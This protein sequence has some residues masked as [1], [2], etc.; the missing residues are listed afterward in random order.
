MKQRLIETAMEGNGARAEY[1]EAAL[2]VFDEHPEYVDELFRLAR[3]QHPVALDRFVGD[4]VRDLHDRKLAEL[5]AGYLA[6][7]PS[8]L[9]EILIR[10]LEASEGL[11]AARAATGRAIAARRRIAAGIITDDAGRAEALLLATVDRLAD[12]RTARQALLRVMQARA[13]ELVGLIT[14]DPAALR[15]MLRAIVGAD[16][17]APIELP[18]E[19]PPLR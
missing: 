16:L 14:R 10:T 1:L 11:P 7:S 2:R 5:A 13:R 17:G 4:A 12:K 3:A 15:A 8:S 6:R 9:E 18:A 19:A